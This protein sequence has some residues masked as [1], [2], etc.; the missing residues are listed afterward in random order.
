[1]GNPGVA[2]FK[3]HVYTSCGKLQQHQAILGTQYYYVHLLLPLSEKLS[4]KNIKTNI[5][6]DLVTLARPTFGTQGL[7]FRNLLVSRSG[8]KPLAF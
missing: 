4:S 7:E 5:V 3:F 2:A 6:I 8:D 1:M